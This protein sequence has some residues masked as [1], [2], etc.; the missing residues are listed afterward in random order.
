MFDINGDGVGDNPS[1]NI[2]CLWNKAWSPYL[3]IPA[4]VVTHCVEPFQIPEETNLE[5]VTSNWTPINSKKQYR[6]KNQLDNVPRM[7]WETD[8][9]KSTFELHC[10]PDGYFTWEEWPICLT[11]VTCSPL[12]PVIPT[13]P[14][15]TLTSDDGHVIINSLVY[16]TY[17]T[18][19]RTSNLIKRS[20]FSNTDIP[21]N[22]MANLT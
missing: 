12:P 2:R 7:F 3:E 14:E 9:S 1:L 5:E 13:D 18:E 11:D 21:K 6:C 4:C 17:P 19:T 15:Y 8:R 20:D 16:P 22:F 10:N